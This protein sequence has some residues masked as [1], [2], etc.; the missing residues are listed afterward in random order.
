M[1]MDFGTRIVPNWVPTIN[2]NMWM[3]SLKFKLCGG[4]SPYL[5]GSDKCKEHKKRQPGD[6]SL[7]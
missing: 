4:M 7:E 5:F 3:Y 1:L 6:P 2:I